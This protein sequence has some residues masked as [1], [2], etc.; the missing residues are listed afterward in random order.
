MKI[1][2]KLVKWTNILAV[3]F[4]FGVLMIFVAVAFAGDSKRVI[5]YDK[6]DD[7]K[8]ASH[9]T[10]DQQMCTR[11]FIE[12]AIENEFMGQTWYFELNKD[13][14]YI[15]NAGDTE[16]NRCGIIMIEQLWMGVTHRLTYKTFY[17][18]AD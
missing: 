12:K 4:S 17:E 8:I 10:F 5:E 15:R 1:N 11:F 9:Y 2:K 7:V 18:V 16:S 3:I 6:S 14:V 13:D